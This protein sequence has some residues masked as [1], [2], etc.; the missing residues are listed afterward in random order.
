MIASTKLDGGST[1]PVA[2]NVTQDTGVKSM[3]VATAKVTTMRFPEGWVKALEKL[4]EGV[5]GYSAF[6]RAL[7][8][9]VLN[10]QLRVTLGPDGQIVSLEGRNAEGKRAKLAFGAGVAPLGEALVAVGPLASAGRP[11]LT[12]TERAM[13]QLARAAAKEGVDPEALK[14]RIEEAVPAKPKRRKRARSG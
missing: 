5:G 2:E 14:Q 12:E 6:L 11:K 4:G 3:A 13:R 10:G 8:W 7:A 9:P 1:I